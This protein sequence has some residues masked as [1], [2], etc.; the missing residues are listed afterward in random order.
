MKN[1]AFLFQFLIIVLLEKKYI[2]LRFCG[3]KQDIDI[4]KK[5]VQIM[6]L[7]GL[8]SLFLTVFFK[9]AD[10]RLQYLQNLPVRVV[11]FLAFS[12]PKFFENNRCYCFRCLL[13]LCRAYA[14]LG[15]PLP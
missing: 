8:D 3:T 14:F 4:E 12:E 9:R 1:R 2:V 10:R 5:T 11:L 7:A 15:L 6:L 13:L